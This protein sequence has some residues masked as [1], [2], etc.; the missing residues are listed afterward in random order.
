MNK[1]IDIINQLD[2]A[3]K[4]LDLQSIKEKIKLLQRVV[5]DIETDEEGEIFWKENNRILS[6]QKN[7]LLDELIQIL[8]T[9]TLERTQYYIQRLIKSLTEEK[10]SKIN[11]LNL[12]RWKEYEDILTDSLWLLDKRDNSGA[13][14]AGYWGNFV[15]QIPN[16]LL[17]RYTKQGEWL[18]DTFLG[19]G[20]S[21]M[22]CK[23]L[24]RN[25]I[26]IELQE[27][28]VNLAKENIGKDITSVEFPIKTEIINANCL[29]V[30]YQALL[31]KLKIPSVQLILMHPPYWDIIRF[32]DSEKD[33]SNALT[34]ED[35]LLKIGT[36]TDLVFPIL[37]KGRYLALIISDKYVKGEW[38][39]LGFYTMQEVLKR[40]FKLKSIIVKNF[41]ETKGKMNQK[42]LWRY[43]ALA[44][45]F[46]VF[47]HEYIY[48]FQKTGK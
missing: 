43:R 45:G 35:F 24:G 9:H 28:V 26:G 29:E 22:E 46:Y 5:I 37:E 39:P 32:S 14:S 16:Q 36:L 7:Y 20:T 30:D 41:E 18:L 12:N 31:Q 21:L 48:L 15:P 13:H 4:I 17:R 8:E 10:T 47:K 11:D 2:I 44:G 25:G 23:R 33:L 3:L 27:D 38:I 6:F 42:E 40:K 1:Q 19:S 34:L